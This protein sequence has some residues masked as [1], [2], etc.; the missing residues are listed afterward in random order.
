[1][2]RA[3]CAYVRRL[4][5]VH[6]RQSL[7]EEPFRARRSQLRKYF[8]PHDLSS[9]RL[10]RNAARFA[11]VEYCESE[12]GREKV[13]EFWQQA[14]ESRSEGLMIKVIDFIVKRTY[15]Q[16]RSLIAFPQLLDSGDVL[17][18]E[19]GGSG[20]SRKKP[21]PATYEPGKPSTTSMLDCGS[22]SLFCR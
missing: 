19:S 3:E 9:P 15:P 5:R 11:H 17:E 2:L 12:W 22:D 20:R 13:E 18:E 1:M 7:L 14:L 10:P 4:T 21:L 16:S 8:P 6:V